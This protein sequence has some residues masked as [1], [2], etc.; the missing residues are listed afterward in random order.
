MSTKMIIV[1]ICVVFLVAA[2]LLQILA[3]RWAQGKQ[4]QPGPL[5]P[6]EEAAKRAL[7]LAAL[8]VRGQ[9]ETILGMARAIAD[10]DPL[11]KTGN[12]KL[13]EAGTERLNRW[14][15]EEGLWDSLSRKERKL[16]T[17]D[18]GKWSPQN[19][20]DASWRREAAGV[21]AWSVGLLPALPAWDTQI[22]EDLAKA[23]GFQAPLASTLGRIL[24]RPEDEIRKARDIAERWL[25]R[26]RTTQLMKERPDTP[27]PKGM[28]F[29]KIIRMAAEKCAEDGLFEPI[30][31]DFPAMG[32]A[33]HELTDDEW[34]TMC[35]IATER[36]Y[37]LNWLC[38]YSADWDNVRCDT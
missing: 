10:A 32:K 17:A 15:R 23:I 13:N 7:C 1:I 25:W 22:D 11:E 5:V 8:I 27:M 12:Q 9:L 24:P 31:G 37:A 36:L 29:G 4:Q 2:S 16:M 38:S 33:Y 3:R 20:M 21:I 18:C 6:P 35:S 34:N 26:A 19:A 30:R 28:T 14:L